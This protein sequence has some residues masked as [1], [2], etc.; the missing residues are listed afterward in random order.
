MGCFARQKGG[1][2]FRV[3][4][5]VLTAMSFLCRPAAADGP[6]SAESPTIKHMPPPVSIERN[7]IAPLADNVRYVTCL[8][9]TNTSDKVI[10]ALRIELRLF[11]A[12]GQL[13][14]QFN[15]D[16]SGQFSPRVLIEGPANGDEYNQAVN[17][18]SLFGVREKS[19]NCWT[20]QPNGPS[21]RQTL[22]LIAVVFADGS[23][24]RP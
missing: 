18:G 2:V 14:G 7:W 24:W 19:R 22:R 13:Q 5:L 12:A 17:G 16:R 8:S 1:S 21:T 11:D 20:T 6:S 15:L 4:V 10:T 9:F 23:S 3:T